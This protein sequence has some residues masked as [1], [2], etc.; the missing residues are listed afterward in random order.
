MKDESWD[1]TV[2]GDR[3][4]EGSKHVLVSH[5][6]N[7]YILRVFQLPALGWGRDAAMKQN[8]TVP[9]SVECIAQ[10]GA[11]TVT[12]GCWGEMVTVT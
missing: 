6:L 10:R 7:K 9:A 11:R 1:L 3:G 2:V 8:N 12:Q 4:R 5:S